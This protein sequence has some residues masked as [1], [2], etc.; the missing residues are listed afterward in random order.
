[1]NG[2][3]HWEQIVNQRHT[4]VQSTGRHSSQVIPFVYYSLVFSWEFHRDERWLAGSGKG[5]V[6]R[7]KFQKEDGNMRQ[8]GRRSRGAAHFRSGE[9]A[10]GQ[11]DGG[12]AKVRLKGTRA[13]RVG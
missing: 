9:R 3:H 7:W 13:R 8:Q 12:E 11:A 10:T 1:M 2:R 5:V 4:G 6:T